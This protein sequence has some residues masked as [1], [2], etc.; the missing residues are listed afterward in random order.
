MRVI[1]FLFYSMACYM[2]GNIFALL[3]FAEFGA[4]FNKIDFQNCMVL[5]TSPD[6]IIHST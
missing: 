5:F 4:L 1:G 6:I 2:G 3:T